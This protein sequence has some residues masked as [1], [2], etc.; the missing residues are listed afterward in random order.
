MRPFP[1]ILA[2]GLWLAGSLSAAA[3]T[4]TLTSPGGFEVSGGFVSFDGEFYRLETEGGAVTL[5]GE[6]LVCRGEACPG[7]VV[8][9]LAVDAPDPSLRRLVSGLL[10]G[11]AEAM[12]WSVV[13]THDEAGL[14]TLAMGPADAPARLEVA[15]TPAAGAWSVLRDP[16]GPPPTGARDKALAFDALVPAVSVENPVTG[17]TL[18][19]V[20]AA[21]AGEFP[22]WVGLGG[23]ET[24]VRVHWADSLAGPLTERYGLAPGEGAVRHGAVDEAADAIA[25][26]PGALGLLPLSEIGNAVPL[27]V[28]GPC[29]RGALGVAAAIRSGDYPLSEVIVLRHSARR[30]APVARSFLSWLGEE[31]AAAS[32]RAAGF[33]A[34]TVNAVPEGRDGRQEAD[35]LTMASLGGSE[36][37]ASEV[38]DLGRANR[39]DVA[40]RFRDGS[41]LPDRASRVQIDRLMRAVEAG[42]FDGRTLLFAGFSD[43]DGA[44]SENLQLSRRRAEAIAALFSGG[45]VRI[46]ARGFGEAMPVACNGADWGESLNRRVEVWLAPEEN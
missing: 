25:R 36:A 46:E 20:R 33:V 24:P 6:G 38:S 4:V 37:S 10:G 27:V 28:T 30:P 45:G 44:A 26:D 40:V 13:E 21:L 29:G 12:G 1:C 17:L 41:S 39:L 3:E 32:V 11:F 16:R 9:R 7:A 35:P 43:A 2:A 5:S 23:D 19:G 14:A 8:E 42:R 31:A 18:L 34:L 15:F 22:D